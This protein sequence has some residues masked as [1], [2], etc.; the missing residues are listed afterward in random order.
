MILEILD[1]QHTCAPGPALDV[2]DTGHVQPHVSIAG[3]AAP[4]SAAGA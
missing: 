4:V 1:R 3:G 2:A